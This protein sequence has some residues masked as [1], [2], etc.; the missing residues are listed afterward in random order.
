MNYMAY[1]AF[2]KTILFP[3]DGRNGSITESQ[4]NSLDRASKYMSSKK[5]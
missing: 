5:R 2:E 1:Y 3:V 4:D